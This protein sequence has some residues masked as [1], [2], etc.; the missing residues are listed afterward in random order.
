MVARMVVVCLPEVLHHRPLLAIMSG[1][2]LHILVLHLRL[3]ANNNSNNHLNNKITLVLVADRVLAAPLAL[4]VHL[5][6]LE[7][8]AGEE[9]VTLPLLKL[10][11][12]AAEVA[13]G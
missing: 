3:A 5:V 12:D 9:E 2:L 7:A 4:P 1:V 10:A 13:R 11:L 6:D 8:E